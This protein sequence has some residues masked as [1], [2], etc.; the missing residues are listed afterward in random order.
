MHN[1]ICLL[2]DECDGFFKLKSEPGK[3]VN[4]H[5]LKQALQRKLL[6]PCFDLLEM[7][8]LFQFIYL[9]VFKKLF[10]NRFKLL[11]FSA[12]ICKC[13]NF[14]FVS[15][16]VLICRMKEIKYCTLTGQMKYGNYPP[17]KDDCVRL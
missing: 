4:V 1:K 8:P 15:R 14:C 11:R 3:H 6:R 17:E 13:S 12:L 10:A 7:I 9:I 16:Q 5:I 2:G